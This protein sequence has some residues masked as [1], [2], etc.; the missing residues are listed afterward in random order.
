MQTFYYMQLFFIQFTVES[1]YWLLAFY[2]FFNNALTYQPFPEGYSIP[3]DHTIV[4]WRI[5]T[6]LMYGTLALEA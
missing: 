6:T 2:M 3:K 1:K 5:D 4:F